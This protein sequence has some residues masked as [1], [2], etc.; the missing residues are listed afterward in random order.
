MPFN[1]IELQRIKK[2]VG[3][4]CEGR[5]PEH[6]LN[7]IKILYEVRGHEVKIIETRPHFIR[8]HEWTEHPVARMKYD[9][10]TLKWQLYW[11]RASGKWMKYPE[12]TPTSRLQSLIEVI[13][14]DRFGVF[15]G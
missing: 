13:K 8:K 7:Q 11:R 12:L 2:V 5:I 15:W 4:F 6:L 14:E 1:D 9:P 10:G 3:E